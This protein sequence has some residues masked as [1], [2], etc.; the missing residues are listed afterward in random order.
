M[1]SA[2]SSAKTVRTPSPDPGRRCCGAD[3]KQAMLRRTA[4]HLRDPLCCRSTQR[5]GRGRRPSLHEETAGSAQPS[6][7][8]RFA[9]T[10][11][12]GGRGLFVAFLLQISRRNHTSAWSVIC[13]ATE[14]AGVVRRQEND[15]KCNACGKTDCRCDKGG[16]CSCGKDCACVKKPQGSK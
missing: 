9:R 3:V 12:E 16:K 7:Q 4:E 10:S 2:C 11:Q 8:K 15:M 14:V 13:I 5:G 1:E 6:C